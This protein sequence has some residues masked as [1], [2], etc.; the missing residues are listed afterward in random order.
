[1]KL[2]FNNLGVEMSWLNFKHMIIASALAVVPLSVGAVTVPLTDL[3][4]DGY[5]EAS[6]GFS[7][8]DGPGDGGGTYAEIEYGFDRDLYDVALQI[9]VTGTGTLSYDVD[10]YDYAGILEPGFY[11]YSIGDVVS[12]AVV[13]LYFS[14]PVGSVGFTTTI[15]GNA[16]VPL[17]AAGFMALAG[18]TA[19]GSLGVARRRRSLSRGLN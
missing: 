2:H 7:P 5:Y 6:F 9:A 8:F 19:L 17:P 13:T 15:V 10:G 3:D 18:F 12:G 4:G 11:E 1:L 16:Y 14:D